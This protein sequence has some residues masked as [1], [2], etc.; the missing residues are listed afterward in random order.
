[1]Q[2]VPPPMMVHGNCV[3]R[4]CRCCRGNCALLWTPSIAWLAPDAT[5]TPKAHIS[6][7]QCHRDG[8]IVEHG[9]QDLLQLRVGTRK[10]IMQ[11]FGGLPCCES[12]LWAMVYRPVYAGLRN[13]ASDFCY[14]LAAPTVIV[15]MR[16]D[17][18]TTKVKWRCTARMSYASNAAIMEELEREFLN[19]DSDCVG[20]LTT[21]PQLRRGA[22]SGE[23]LFERRR[24]R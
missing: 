24:R 22:M 5:H 3:F 12:K 11:M 6:W 21:E 14:A 13:N 2:P 18:M 20:W 17:G 23:R 19:R 15:C 8:G 16:S 7:S 4:L 1:M 9:W 10:G